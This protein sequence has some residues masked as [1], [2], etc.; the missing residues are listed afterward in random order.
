MTMK[1]LTITISILIVLFLGCKFSSSSETTTPTKETK[2]TSSSD[3]GTIEFTMNGEKISTP[4]NAYRVKTDKHP[5]TFLSVT[6]SQKGGKWTISFRLNGDS[7][8]SY[9]LMASGM[10]G[11]FRDSQ[12]SLHSLNETPGI[13][14]DFLNGQ[15][16]IDSVDGEGGGR[17][18]GSFI[19]TAVNVLD[20]N[21]TLNITDGKFIN[22]R[23]N[24]G[25]TDGGFK[26]IK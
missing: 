6:G 26:P 20:K 17:L 9:T 25:T 7:A 18:T 13:S 5:N 19:T 14:Y 15:V 11:I 8:K 21:K 2:T 4:C 1:N 22:C 10:A 16:T 3:S 24:K 12:G 23:M